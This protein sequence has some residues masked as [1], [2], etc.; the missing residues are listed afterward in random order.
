MLKLYAMSCGRIRSRKKIYI[1][2]APKEEYVEAPMPVFLVKHPGGNLLFDT[3]PNP[4]VFINADAVWGG[5]A[6]AFQPIGDKDSGVVAQ[7]KNRLGLAPDDISYVV[8]SHLHFDHSG[9]NRFFP[10]ATFLVSQ[11]EL[12]CARR[13]DLEGKGYFRAE[14]DLPLNYRT[15]EG[16]L[17]VFGDG[18]I[19]I[20]PM[21]GHTPGHQAM[22]VRLEKHD[23]ILLS[24]DSAA[25]RENF[26]QRVLPLNHLNKEE[27]R[28][29]I[30]RLHE[31]MAKQKTMIIY[32]H[33]EE[34]W[35][36]LKK[37]PA[38]YE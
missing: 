15:V 19:I 16:E 10:D 7:L 30:D 17:D 6:K 12:E 1:P 26:E 38:Y 18:R 3:G 2:S 32:G 29:S 20:Y 14:W 4:E 11:R 36:S 23:P 13:P 37:A 8:N 27:A 9:G 28:L 25:F 5:L 35:K 34:Q 24:G 33:D 22:L 31:L 21:P